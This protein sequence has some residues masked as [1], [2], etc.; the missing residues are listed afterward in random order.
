MTDDFFISIVDIMRLNARTIVI[1]IIFFFVGLG[2]TIGFRNFQR[3]KTTNN[4]PENAALT[5]ASDKP[6]VQK[7]EEF[8]VT[9]TLDSQDTEVAAADFVVDFDPKKL[10]VV[11]IAT[12]SFFTNYPVNT[13]GENF[14][15]L[16]GVASFDGEVLTLPKGKDVV[17]HITFQ[18]LENTGKTEVKFNSS[19]TIVATAGKNILDKKN[20]AKT[21]VEVL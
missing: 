18:A 7:G 11:S 10:K 21:E 19:K 4:V 17:G 8:T 20:L 12:G 9:I 2:I 1:L 6:Q 13:T 5:L 16:S 14:V 3:S 15:K